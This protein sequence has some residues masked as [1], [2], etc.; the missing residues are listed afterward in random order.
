MQAIVLAGG[1]GTRLR[2]IVSDV[3]KP[4]AP[5]QG[6]PF[7]EILLSNLA[8]QGFKKVV[9]AVGY[10]SD[11]IIGHFGSNYQNLKID[12]VI[13]DEPL[14]TGGAVKFA[15]TKISDEHC[16]IF[17]GDTFLDLEI[18]RVEKVW[19]N[20][21]APIMVARH[22]PDTTRFGRLIVRDRHIVGFSEKGVTGPGLINAG[23][24]V[25]STD[26]LIDFQM[27]RQFSLETDYFQAK[28]TSLKL[29]CF[30][31]KGKF[32]DIGIPE[33]FENAQTLLAE[34]L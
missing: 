5:V 1:F 9:L 31:T 21:S 12:Y 6:R 15:L 26:A 27:G 29:R 25:L 8:R 32:I 20:E 24:Y 34:Y 17:N 11:Q 30:E 33:D 4:M 19:Q 18:E 7:M 13:E 22:V 28:I 10:L 2:S 14:G 23:C 16:F 3:P